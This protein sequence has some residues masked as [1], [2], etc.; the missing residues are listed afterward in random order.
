[1][2]VRSTE[3]VPVA[4]AAPSAR[5]S[6]RGFQVRR[7]AGGGHVLELWGPLE[8]GWA[9]P[10]CRGLARAGLSIRSG[11]AR[12]LADGPP[13]VWSALF[14]I[15]R[16]RVSTDPMMLDYLELVSRGRTRSHAPIEL[17]DY[18]LAETAAHGGSLLVEIH[19]RD[20]V[21]FLGG[22]LERLTFLG[23]VPHEM[24]IETD[25]GGVDDRFWLKTQDG[26]VPSE[27]SRKLLAEVLDGRLLR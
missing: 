24:R 26:L 14:Q 17:T 8:A 27:A 1:M 4:D 21:G 16:A 10:L 18:Q 7:V 5:E 19:G 25:G 15:E 20:H 3:H 12:R 11:T 13:P 23:L 6:Q 22:F 2:W 9:D